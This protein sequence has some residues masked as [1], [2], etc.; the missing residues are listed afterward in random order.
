MRITP[1]TAL[2]RSI[3]LGCALALPAALWA[4]QPSVRVEPPAL[5]GS[6]SL[7]KLTA[8]SVVRDYLQSWKAF[9]QAFAQNQPG[10]LRQDFVGTALTRLS[11]T[12][13]D[14]KKLGLQ[15][16][17]EDR[18]HHLQIVF[19][20]PDGLS[21]QLIDQV[22][23]DQQVLEGGKVLTSHPVHARYLVVMTPSQTRW[24]VRIFQATPEQSSQ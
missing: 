16:R 12:I 18:S 2:R 7:E 4:D 6:R 22:D 24:Q 8:N 11:D 15:T 21:I 3:V 14:Q 5:N 10:I 9:R 13:A 1:R 23:Y 20:S 19:Y 17:Y